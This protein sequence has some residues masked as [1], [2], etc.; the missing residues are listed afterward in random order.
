LIH[1]LKE[2]YAYL[3]KNI[4]STQDIDALAQ[5]RDVK[6]F[7]NADCDEPSSLSTD[8]RWESAD[9]LVFE[10]AETEEAYARPVRRFLQPY[11]RLL[12]LVG[13]LR[14]YYPRYV[15]PTAS[16]SEITKLRSIR[17]EFNRMRQER[18]LTD[19]VFITEQ[20][21]ASGQ[22]APPHELVAHRSFLAA[23][24]G[25]FADQFKPV[26]R[27]GM[28]ASSANPVRVPMVEHSR[29]CVELVLG[30]SPHSITISFLVL[31]TSQILYTP[32]SIL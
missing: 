13:V 29:A 2:T 31:L 9:S 14:V 3:S 23:S 18:I 5:I 15:G 6:V 32:A 1:D 4:S 17:S 21:E 25:N 12:Q 19:V 26:F 20:D 27:E 10:I 22:E 7:L 30:M 24:G 8:W 16:H 28:A 11:E